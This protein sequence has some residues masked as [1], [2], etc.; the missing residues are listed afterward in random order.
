M[1]L[2]PQEL[3]DNYEVGHVIGQGHYALVRECKDIN[4][5]IQFALKIIDLKNISENVILILTSYFFNN[6]YIYGQILK[7]KSIENELKIL[8]KVKHTNIVKLVEE[9]RTNRFIYLIMEYLKVK[10]INKL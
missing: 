4:T 7:D 8:R 5:G 6:K 1:N 2:L 3:L 9:Y 10:S